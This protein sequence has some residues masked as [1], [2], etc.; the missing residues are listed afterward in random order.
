MADGAEETPEVCLVGGPGGGP[1]VMGAGPA[2]R[3]R[4]CNLESKAL[5]RQ[6]AAVLSAFF[7]GLDRTGSAPARCRRFPGAR[8]TSGILV[9]QACAASP[10]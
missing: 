10:Q 6:P 7:S 8:R 3:S 5:P 1:R 4:V 9:P 2:S